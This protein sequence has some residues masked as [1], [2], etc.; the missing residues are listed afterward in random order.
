MRMF[1]KWVHRLKFIIP[2]LIAVTLYLL[3]PY[4][5][6]VAETVFSRGIFQVISVPVGGLISALPFSV[7][8]MLAVLAIPVTVLLLILLIRRV[9]RNPGRRRAVLAKASRICGWVLS[10]TLLLYMLLHGVNFY[11][12]PADQLLELDTAVCTPEFL[13]EICIDLAQKASAEREGLVEDDDGCMKLSQSISAT[14]RQAS[15]GYRALQDEIPILW[16]GVSRAKP[17][18]LSHL[19]SYTGISGM[20]FP[21]LAEANVNIDQPDFYIPA[22][23]AHELAHTRGF[24]REDECNFFAYLTCIQNESQDFRYS[25]YVLAYTYCIGALYGYNQDMGREA[26]SH[27]SETMMRDLRSGSEYWKQFE[28]KIRQ[29]AE[30]VND[31]FIQAQGIEDGVLSYGRVVQLIV[32]IYRKG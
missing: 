21:M 2:G 30:K 12:F 25:G 5:P 13:M 18:Q 22:T 29:T 1:F 8:E 14:L 31:S 9:I 26:A 27:C 32:G 19:W 7:T 17:V 4:F 20:Y 10:V 6:R 15:S 28:G 16:G 24:A 23:A 3:L 11:R